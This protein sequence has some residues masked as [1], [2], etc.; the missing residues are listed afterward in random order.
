MADPVDNSFPLITTMDGG[1]HWQFWPAWSATASGEASFAASGTCLIL[2]RN[3]KSDAIAIVSGGTR[4]GV[5]QVSLD[6]P[7]MD[8]VGYDT[9]IV[10]GSAGSG[11]FSIAMRD[12]K[13]GVIVG[14]NYE[15]PDEAA[16]NV[17]YTSDGG[18]TW[19]LG[20]GLGGY[21]SGVAFVAKNSYIAV[22]TNGVDYSSDGGR[23]WQPMNKENLNAVQSKGPKATWAAGPKGLIMKL[24]K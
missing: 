23:T 13:N 22:G 9:P 11:I 24:N 7:S 3:G 2:Y 8:F 19:T 18:K 21:R 17:A 6:S 4:S 5:Y 16:K 1:A 10:R 20:S 12:A 14:G 15:K